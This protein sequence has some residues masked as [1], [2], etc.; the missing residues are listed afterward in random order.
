MSVA[1]R[2]HYVP[3]CLLKHFCVDG[4]TIAVTD[5][6]TNKTYQTNIIN[7]AQENR[8]YNLDTNKGKI[9]LKNNYAELESNN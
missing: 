6:K 5:L 8:F 2:Q 7:V 4:Q 9:S 1:K 3:R